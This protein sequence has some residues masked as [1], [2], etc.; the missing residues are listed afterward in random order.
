MSKEITEIKYGYFIDKSIEFST[1]VTT[2]FPSDYKECLISSLG[3]CRQAYDVLMSQRIISGEDA[4]V[5]TYN[6]NIIPIDEFIEMTD[7]LNEIEDRNE[8]TKEI[9]KMI[10][11]AIDND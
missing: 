11:D 8:F 3:M 5:V 6:G 7:E 10:N 4:F 9:M 2:R 1:E